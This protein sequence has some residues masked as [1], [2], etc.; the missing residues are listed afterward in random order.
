M[1][2]A[3]L[4]AP[5]EVTGHSKFG[6]I[7]SYWPTLLENP[8][9]SGQI[10]RV[11]A[12]W[13]NP[14][15]EFYGPGAAIIFIEYPDGS[16][17]D[18]SKDWLKS[19]DTFRNNECLRGRK[20]YLPEGARITNNVTPEQDTFASKYL[21]SYERIGEPTPVW[22]RN[23]YSEPNLA[24]PQSIVGKTYSKLIQGTIPVVLAN[25][26]ESGYVLK[27][28][29][30]FF[31]QRTDPVLPGAYYITFCVDGMPAYTLDYFQSYYTREDAIT[32]VP[33]YTCVYL[34]EGQS[35]LI[36]PSLPWED[37]QIS[38]NFV[39]EIIGSPPPAT[40]GVDL[41]VVRAFGKRNRNVLLPVRIGANLWHELPTLF[42]MNIERTLTDPLPPPA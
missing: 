38:V 23:V 1:N 25:P 40:I 33:P 19:G 7:G 18:L 15:I 35:L 8:V 11:V 6:F 36:E 24:A 29:N 41:N 16:T 4:H 32:F 30:C 37:W 39:Y 34:E 27:V 22:D 14:S 17:F 12:F 20:I 3:N 31:Y 21:I 5:E 13:F 10:I 42:S 2:P 26:R 9:G 28:S